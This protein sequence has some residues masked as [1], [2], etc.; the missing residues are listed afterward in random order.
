M[1]GWSLWSRRFGLHCLLV[2]V[3]LE[4]QAEDTVQN[5]GFDTDISHWST[6]SLWTIEWQSDE[7]FMA[8]GAISVAATSSGG[9]IGAVGP[10]QCVS[11]R[12]GIP[13]DIGVAFKEDPSSTQA[14]AGRLRISWFSG[15]S[16]TSP[17]F[18]VTDLDP[19]PGITGWQD[20]FLPEFI[21]PALAMSARV[22]LIQS[23][24]DV[25]EFAAFW[26]DVLLEP[27]GEIFSDGFELGDIS[28]WSS[29][30]P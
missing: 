20:L 27:T 17:I 2:F 13:Y 9:S 26:D 4:V 16:C 22:N 3:C 18:P 30:A 28:R 21:S 15:L 23:V 14:G 25:G 29:S 6:L 1:A 10:S 8:S 7:G 24:D 12:P 19:V 5:P 11:V